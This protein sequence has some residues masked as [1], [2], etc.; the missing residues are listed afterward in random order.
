MS[1]CFYPYLQWILSDITNIFIVD[2][3]EC[4]FML[5]NVNKNAYFVHGKKRVNFITPF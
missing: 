4:K 2:L 5:P 1:T 3:I